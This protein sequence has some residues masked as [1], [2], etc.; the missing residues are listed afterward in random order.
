MAYTLAD[1]T[2]YC[3]RHGWRGAA[4]ADTTQLKAWINDTIQ[5]LAGMRNW[6]SYRKPYYIGLTAPYT[7][8]TVTVTNESA[9]VTGSGTSWASGMVGQEFFTGADGGRV[10]QITA[11]G[12][13]TSLTLSQ[14][15]LG[16]SGAS[17]TYSIRYVRY[18][19][20]SDFD[21]PYGGLYDEFGREMRASEVSLGELSALRMQHRGTMSLPTHV[22]FDKGGPGQTQTTSIYFHPAPSAVYMLRGTYQASPVLATDDVAPDWPERFRHLLHEALRMEVTTQDGKGQNPVTISNFENMVEQAYRRDVQ[23]TM[24]ISIRVGGRRDVF[25]ELAEFRSQYTIS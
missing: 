9:T 21:R 12:G 23:K 22:A 24:P 1:L 19:M 14:T 8:G 25:D 18:G 11:V 4:V 2:T 16:T 7:T 20:A 5:R 6:P 17:Q 3:Q 15:F 13:T 10:Y